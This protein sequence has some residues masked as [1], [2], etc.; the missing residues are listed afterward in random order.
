[1]HGTWQSSDVPYPKCLAPPEEILKPFPKGAYID[2]KHFDLYIVVVLLEENGAFY[3]VHAADIR[4]VRMAAMGRPRPHTLNESDGAGRFSVGKTDYFSLGGTTGIDKALELHTGN[5]VLIAAVP[6]LVQIGRVNGL[7]SRGHDYGAHI[8]LKFFIV[9]GKI[10]TVFSA[11][12]Y[13]FTTN[14]GVMSQAMIYIYHIR[15]GNGLG[16]G[17]IDGSSGI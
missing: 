1:L 15:S 5:D 12:L 3:G 16:E 11:N 6:V 14:N 4:A 7:G 2:V 10:D 13:A 9:H 17:G 8:E